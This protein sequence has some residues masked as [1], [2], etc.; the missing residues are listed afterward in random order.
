MP[1]TQPFQRLGGLL[2]GGLLM[3]A[4]WSAPASAQSLEE[5]LANTYLTNPTLL[6]A[7]AE[8]RSV[9]EGVP[10]ALSAWRPQVTIS[11]DVGYETSKLL[12]E[13]LQPT[14][15]YTAGGALTVNQTIYS[16]GSIRASVDSAEAVV[17]AQRALLADTEQS[18]LLAAVTA[19][20]DV[21]QAK[22]ILDL[23][24]A[25]EER[26]RRQREAT[27]DR[28]NVGEVTRTDV[29]QADARLAGATADRV[30]AEGDL[31]TAQSIFYQII[32]LVPTE[33]EQ[34]EPI[35]ILPRSL[36]ETVAYAQQDAPNL[37]AARFLENSALSDIRVQLGSLL[38][39]VSLIGLLDYARDGSAT[40]GT[41]DLDIFTAT[42][43]AQVSIPLYQQGLVSSQVRQAKQIA[44]QR[45][46]EI[47]EALRQA[48]QDGVTAWES[49][50][51]ARAQI[52]SFE[53]QVRANTVALE[54]VEQESLVGARTV[55]DVLD[56]E[57]E[58]LQAQV[59]LVGAQRDEVVAA[60]QVSSAIGRLTAANLNLGVAIY[61]PRIDYDAVRDRWFGLDAPG[62]N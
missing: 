44:S 45:R 13:N 50:E 39:Q 41:A 40:S 9:N 38:P 23:N 22:A 37:V 54:G 2:A 8:L 57:Q 56:A 7:R 33:V 16:G 51:T 62:T 11:G 3:A 29:S 42:I 12:G 18:V 52:T 26:L 36:Q 59:S 24:I 27:V 60:Y 58:L 32:G 48:E 4:A 46:L 17:F 5:A 35:A 31:A 34:A 20:I 6:A 1:A 47:T 61:N 21:W 15:G 43:V 49:L 28:F 53:S 19:Y 10:Q 25:N 30:A 14:S 55:L